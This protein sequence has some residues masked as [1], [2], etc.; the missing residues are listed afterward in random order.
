MPDNLP[1][2]NPNPAPKPDADMETATNAAPVAAASP[3]LPVRKLPPYWILRTDAGG[4]NY[5]SPG[6]LP[7]VKAFNER[8]ARF[9]ADTNYGP[10]PDGKCNL[11]T[12]LPGKIPIDQV[13]DFRY[14]TETELK[15]FERA[16]N[17]FYA[18]ADPDAKTPLHAKE[19]RKNF[20][21]PDPKLEPDAYRV[22]GDKYDPKL[23]VFW[24]CEKNQG[25]SLPLIRYDR[26]GYKSTSVYDRLKELLLS[27]EEQQRQAIELIKEINDP[28]G[29]FIASPVF[30]KG[31]LV[32]I[33]TRTGTEIPLDQLKKLKPLP[34][35]SLARGEFAAFRKA[36]MDFYAKA[37]PEEADA[38]ENENLPV[39][40]QKKPAVG[41]YEKELRRNFRLPDPDRMP[42]C[43]WMFKGRLFVLYGDPYLV[44]ENCLPLCTD[45][46]LGVPV[47]PASKPGAKAE[48]DVDFVEKKSKAAPPPALTVVD[49]LKLR[50]KSAA[51]VLAIAGG[52]VG[53]MLVGALVAYLSIDKTPPVIT[54]AEISNDVK[55]DPPNKRNK[56]VVV[57][58]KPV[59]PESVTKAKYDL[60][61]ASGNSL[62]KISQAEPDP[63][64]KKRL[65]LTLS[66]TV[67]ETDNYSLHIE[68]VT[69][70]TR[71]KNQVDKNKPVSV[72]AADLRPPGCV[73]VSAGESLNKLLV[74]FDEPVGKASAESEK[75]Y[76]VAGMNITAAQVTD[77]RLIVLQADKSFEMNKDYSLTIKLVE[78]QSIAHKSMGTVT[79]PFKYVD[80]TPLKVLAVN[81][82]ENQWT[83]TIDFSKPVDSATAQ[84]VSYFTIKNPDLKVL[85][86]KPRG[87]RSVVLTTD[88][89]TV[90]SKY[91]LAVRGVKSVTGRLVDATNE[92]I[93]NPPDKESP[94][95][96]SP[97]LSQDGAKLIVPFSKVLNSKLVGATFSLKVDMGGNLKDWSGQPKPS[98]GS[99]DS[100]VVLDL[101]AKLD[102][103]SYLL[104]YDKVS[105]IFGNSKS[106]AV[107]FNSELPGGRMIPS[108]IQADT[109]IEGK[110]E[111]K[112]VLTEGKSN[113]EDG[114][115]AASNFEV[116][117]GDAK[118]TVAGVDPEEKKHPSGRLITI[119]T[120]KFDAATKLPAN[121][122]LRWLNV[123]MKGFAKLYNVPV[124][125]P[126]RVG[127]G[128]IAPPTPPPNP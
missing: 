118:L 88:L 46:V 10:S 95:A 27:W 47:A 78:D 4:G 100:E 2:S 101:G 120:V 29:R 41:S 11:I 121:V 30:E 55:M 74:E 19:L 110:S 31:K 75:N 105:D 65:I 39:G 53:L 104:C 67:R 9:L 12:Y 94:V 34:K 48:E 5:F 8:L 76:Q 109:D 50:E 124:N 107:S 80:N 82:T 38:E 122:N 64:D 93:Y 92:F 7:V 99:K 58:N 22:Y 128:V 119:V 14:I 89:L 81:A 60:K 102:Q 6:T 115:F 18:K 66:E 68:G 42:D 1:N 84:D 125:G 114:C 126:Y 36:C 97:L 98:M 117:S 56:L 70:T 17:S 61:S 103:G 21:L 86:S 116:A 96:Q 90:G 63:T 44:K 113:L 72:V 32:K 73:S 85:S 37:H 23:L 123:K 77:P 112:F 79:V 16:A 62:M 106:N 87:E 13:R 71:Q 51:V 59:A 25:S 15:A 20:R 33:L 45:T 91:Q 35:R 111:F 108:I 26:L 49:K 43:F 69:D 52:V 57:F 24:G 54:G 40:E 83:I 28:L 3:A 127:G